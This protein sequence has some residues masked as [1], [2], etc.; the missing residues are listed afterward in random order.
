MSETCCFFICIQCRR[1]FWFFVG[2]GGRYNQAISRVQAVDFEDY[3]DSEY[4]SIMW[5][6][7]TLRMVWRVEPGENWMVM[8]GPVNLITTSSTRT[9]SGVSCSPEWYH[10]I[11]KTPCVSYKELG[12]GWCLQTLAG[13]HNFWGGGKSEFGHKK[14]MEGGSV[15]SN[16]SYRYLQKKSLDIWYVF[17][18]FQEIHDFWC[19]KKGSS[20]LML[21][22]A[23]ACP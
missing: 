15:S 13:W 8:T 4:A 18:I 11:T 10:K 6:S 1:S 2:E 12:G 9:F 19:Q 23:V 7:P 5:P 20:E 3:L 21:W 22:C 17:P 14:V 16:G